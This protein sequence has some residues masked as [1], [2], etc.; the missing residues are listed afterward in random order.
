MDKIYSQTL[1]HSRVIFIF[2]LTMEI[3]LK[4]KKKKLKSDELNY[5]NAPQTNN[6]SIKPDIISIV[7]LTIISMLFV[8]MCYQNNH[9]QDDAFITFRYVNNFVAGHG[10]VFNPGEHVEGFTSFLWVLI[11]VII[12]WLGF[13]LLQ[14]SQV[15]GIAFGIFSIWLTFLIT[16]I[17]FEKFP[18]DDRTSQ[19][20]KGIFSISDLQ[21]VPSAMLAFT[22]AFQYWSI[23][24]MEV[25][26]FTSLSLL[27][28]YLYLQATHKN[29]S[30]TL[31]SICITLTAFVRPEGV[32]LFVAIILHYWSK[33]FRDGE[34]NNPKTFLTKLLGKNKRNPVM[35]FI[36]ANFVL[37]TF[38]FFYFGYPFPNTFYAKTGLSYEY[39]ATGLNYIW[40]FF[41][42]YLFYGSA[43]I[44]ILFLITKTELRSY[45]LLFFSIIILFFLYT[46]AVGGDVLPLFRFVLPALPLIYILFVSGLFLLSGYLIKN[47]TKP[48]MNIAAVVTM[49]ISVGVIYYNYAVPLERID[50]YA[51]YENQLVEKMRASGKW[52]SEKQ[53]EYDHKLV[54][55]ATTIGAVSFYSDAKVI[56]LLGL[57]DETIAHSPRPLRIISGK[58]TGWKERNY[59]VEYVLS[60]KPDFIYF[61]T[62]IKPS[63]YAE[64][65]LFLSEDFVNN[66]YPYF[67]NA[68]GNFVETIYKRKYDTDQRT[69]FIHFSANP[70]FDSNYVNLYNKLLNMKGKP[71]FRER[72]F[73]I[74]NQIEKIGPL[75]F[76]GAR[77]QLGLL[78]EQDRNKSKVVEIMNEAALRDDYLSLAH[79]YLGKHYSIEKNY[80]L[81]QVHFELVQKYNP[82]FFEYQT[83]LRSRLQ[84]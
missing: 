28:I 29:N 81:A 79:F 42:M 11:L 30:L 33:L 76:T 8:L 57:T 44:V 20:S 16:K 71:E 22:G 19:K 43:F 24:G 77:Y 75:N 41:K 17:F 40:D 74:C 54:V 18:A 12:K 23:S 6:K 50:K 21:I 59:N 53:S 3:N 13:E 66:Y 78:F 72:A 84:N 67:F 82:D 38:R 65:A 62:G 32:L 46:I 83:R 56:D 55:A 7:L 69:N 39:L 37:L 1:N 25:T 36:T 49:L 35:I 64:R 51:F 63:A 80:P 2:Q 60:Q 68:I 10:L 48:V 31:F 73:S 4:T 15:A 34:K 45:I 58:H 52:L 61:S 9:I 5:G 70:N 27:S 47:F 14:F 26:L